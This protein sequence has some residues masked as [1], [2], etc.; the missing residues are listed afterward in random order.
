VKNIK[1]K[2]KDFL[3]DQR[4]SKW[5]G[6]WNTLFT[7]K[8]YKCIKPQSESYKK[9]IKYIRQNKCASKKDILAMLGWGQTFGFSSIR[10]QLRCDKRIM[11]TENE[12]IWK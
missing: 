5:F 10:N 3:W 6:N 2:M 4:V 12:Y 8:D 11:L 9:V 7:A 1:P